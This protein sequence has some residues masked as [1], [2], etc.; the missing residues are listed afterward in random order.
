MPDTIITDYFYGDD[1]EAEKEG[2]GDLFY[3]EIGFGNKDYGCMTYSDSK[4]VIGFQKEQ[5]AYLWDST[6]KPADRE[7]YGW[8]A[9]PWVWRVEFE[10]CEKP[11]EAK[12]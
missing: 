2:I 10:R 12:T 5:F 11:E 8:A 9:N 7:R 6:I 4:G 3:E 1:R